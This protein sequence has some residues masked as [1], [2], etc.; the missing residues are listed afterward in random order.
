MKWNDT[1][2]EFLKENFLTKGGKYCADNL[3]R[4]LNAIYKKCNQLKI[5][6]R[7]II[8]KD[9][10][11]N[12]EKLIEAIN[13]SE[14]I[15]QVLKKLNM[16]KFGSSYK[17]FYFYVE[18]YSIET[19][20]KNLKERTNTFLK[21]K[22][23]KNIQISLD[24]ILIE[25]S[26][27]SRTALKKRLYKEGLKQRKCELCGQD[28]NWNG[29]KMSLILDHINGVNDDNRLENLRIV[30]PNCNATLD[31]HCGRNV[32][33]KYYRK[34]RKKYVYKNK[35]NQCVCGKEKT[36]TSDLCFDCNNLKKINFRKVERPSLEI[37][38]KEV[39]DIGYCAVGRKYGVSD[40]CIRKWIKIYKK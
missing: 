27:Y 7:E 26:T 29:K 10:I 8:K 9:I 38:L 31:T 23:I 5:Y 36:K 30:C 17:K 24:L 18:K 14:T 1:D 6:T 37:L 21:S 3:N 11:I 19:E 32:K 40:N 2:V 33:I 16:P 20:F 34:T 12:K 39:D 25:N 22:L 15:I 13:S 35:K 28:E 4:N